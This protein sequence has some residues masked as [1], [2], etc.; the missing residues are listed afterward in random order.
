MVVCAETH[1]SLARFAS[2]DPGVASASGRKVSSRAIWQRLA[3]LGADATSR[4]ALFC[5]LGSCM[6]I[7]RPTAIA[8]LA[9]AD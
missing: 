8:H 9:V 2:E 1:D 7:S 6:S 4:G 5:W 3:M